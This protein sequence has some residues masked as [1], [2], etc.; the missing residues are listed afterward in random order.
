VNSPSG[1]N[2]VVLLAQSHSIARAIQIGSPSHGFGKASGLSS[3]GVTFQPVACEIATTLVTGA[4]DRWS[5]D[6]TWPW[7]TPNIRASAVCVPTIFIAL[8]SPLLISHRNTTY[9]EF[10]QTF[11]HH[12]SLFYN[13]SCIFVLIGILSEILYPIGDGFYAN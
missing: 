6:Q 9:L 8:F 11:S 4:W 10:L 13:Y 3:W 7:R 5:H 12:I 2:L 1:E